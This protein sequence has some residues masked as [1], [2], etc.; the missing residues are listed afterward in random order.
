MGIPLNKESSN[1]TYKYSWFHLAR[2]LTLSGTISPVLVGT[3]YAAHKGIIAVD[4]FIVF[5]IAALLIQ[6]ATNI[7]ND[8]FDFKNGQ[9]TAKWTEITH[10]TSWKNPR[11]H[12]LPYVASVLL[13][14]AFLLGGWLVMQT[15][16]WLAI[17][18]SLGI[19]FGIYYSA[20][21][22][23]FASIGLGEVVAAIFL[24]MMTTILP[25]MIQGNPLDF[26]IIL[27]AIPFALIIATMILTNN[28]RDI[29]K[30]IGHRRTVAMLLGRK[31]AI[32]LLTLLLVSVYI[33]LIVLVVFNIIPKMSMIGLLAIPL[34]IRLRFTFKKEMDAQK[35]MQVMKWAAYHHWMFGL[36]FASVMWLV[37]LL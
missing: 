17:V 37:L 27:I 23:S 28:I 29:I 19:I 12:E 8:Y 7:L 33:S 9:D 34:A 36:L 14:I 20:G 4:V 30:D 16:I 18:G 25:Y 21:N 24:G 35:E 1:F 10:S 11:H 2:P 6:V 5:L 22:F 3:A 13:A 26:Q 32:Q 15:G 31:S